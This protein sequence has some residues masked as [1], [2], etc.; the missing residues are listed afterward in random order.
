MLGLRGN[1]GV[2]MRLS[3]FYPARISEKQPESIKL[4]TRFLDA[5]ASL[6]SIL[7]TEY[8]LIISDY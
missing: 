4:E 1:L 6:R 2:T 8:S 3:I 7:F 5:L